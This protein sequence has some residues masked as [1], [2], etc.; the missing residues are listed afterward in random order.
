MSSP[1]TSAPTLRGA[2]V[3][4]RPMTHADAP[5]VVRWA[6]DPDFAWYQ[7]GRRPGRFPDDNAARKWMD[8][9]AE[10][11]GVMFVIEHEGCA[12]GQANYRD[13]QPK[14]KSA[15]VGIGIGEPE[16]WG[17]G[18]GREA[19]RLLVRHLVDDLGLHRITLSVLAY[20]DRAIASYQAAG[21]EVEG[22]ERDGVMTDKGTWSDDV[23]M[24]YIVGRAR[25][26]FDP[27]PV[28]LNGT[29]VRLEPLRR[30]HAA[31]LLSVAHDEDIWR[32]ML[33]PMPRDVGE[34]ERWIGAALEEQL[35]GNQVAFLTRRIG[36]GA[37]IGST[38][39]LH[40]DR[41]N[42]TAEIGWTFLGR[43]ARRTV[44]NTEAKYLQLR[45][46]FDDLGAHRVWLQTDKLNQRSQRAMERLGAIKEGEHRDD[47]ISHDGRI[48]TS[49]V[50]AITRADWPSVRERIQGLLAR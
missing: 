47:R 5:H 44:A 11:R 33:V 3:T 1:P 9:I 6:N 40:I 35:L 49:V 22:I 41:A 48:R 37:P 46:L 26:T 23:K 30:E 13:V 21:F 10:H 38:R 7:W 24:A 15:E 20:N 32:L 36:D 8:V 28:T 27:R 29:H 4:L 39:F 42:K 12:V 17:K 50:Y 14:G 45:H 19:L 34:L 43:D 18:L 16:L 31:E 25:P 2:R